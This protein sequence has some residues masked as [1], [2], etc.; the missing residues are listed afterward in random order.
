MVRTLGLDTDS[1]L[2]CSEAKVERKAVARE[3]HGMIVRISFL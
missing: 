2:L 3:R 1:R